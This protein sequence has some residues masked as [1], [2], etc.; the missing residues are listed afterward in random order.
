MVF[1]WIWTGI[2]VGNKL[3]VAV[4]PL[5]YLRPVFYLLWLHLSLW[6]LL[7]PAH[8]HVWYQPLMA[9]LALG[10]MVSFISI[11]HSS[12][13]VFHSD[14]LSKPSFS[15]CYIQHHS[16][17]EHHNETGFVNDLWLFYQQPTSE[18]SSLSLTCQR[19]TACNLYCFQTTLKYHF[20]AH[21]LC[22]LDTII[23]PNQHHSPEYSIPSCIDII[24]ISPICNWNPIMAVLSLSHQHSLLVPVPYDKHP[25]H[26]NTLPFTT[27]EAFTYSFYYCHSLQS[28][29]PITLA[30]IQP[31]RWIHDT[32][33]VQDMF[34]WR[35][36][37]QNQLSFHRRKR[38]P[39]WS[40]WGHLHLLS[41]WVAILSPKQLDNIITRKVKIK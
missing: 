25:T 5:F 3:W 7:L 14:N 22:F 41:R 37:D 4:N 26:S 23:P 17:C 11:G 16:L 8:D 36:W 40:W 10:R 9:V 19:N 13:N 20:P 15:L 30:V 32:H 21:S 12:Y 39:R 24:I 29:V 27:I 6:L 2:N 1:H 34:H 31:I 33:N 35:R 18:W 38:I 28:M